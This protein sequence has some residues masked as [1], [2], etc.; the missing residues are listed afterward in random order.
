MSTYLEI[1]V[2]LKESKE[3]NLRLLV[4]AF[5]NEVVPHVFITIKYIRCGF[6][7]QND[8]DEFLRGIAM[9]SKQRIILHVH[10]I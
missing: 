3:S 5:Q 6:A 2:S 9:F 4:N 1:S 7:Y 10:V 8:V